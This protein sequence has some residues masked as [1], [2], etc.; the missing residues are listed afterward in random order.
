MRCWLDSASVAAIALAVAAGAQ[1]GSAGSALANDK[2]NQLSQSTDNWVMPGKNYSANNYS[3]AAQITTEN[4]KRLRSTW[5]FSTGVL[6]GHEGTPLVVNGKMYVHGAFPNPTFAL[7]LNDP[8][9]IL[10]QHKPKQDPTAR[11][12]ACCDLVNRGLAYWPGDGTVP[13]LILKTQLDGH[14]VALNAETGEER[15]KVENSDI[16]VGSTLTIAPFVV[17]DNVIIGSSGA[18]L[19]VRGYLTAYDV[20]TGAQ[21]WRAYATGSDRDMLIGADFNKNTPHYGQHGLGLETEPAIRRRG[22]RPCVPATTN[23]R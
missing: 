22:T 12:V 23:G 7:D 10:W 21:K 17:K 6:N 5:S 18:E 9:K 1:F 2:L 15:W 3:A 4:V 11:A 8:G 16:K 19:G 14:V 13:P 20:K